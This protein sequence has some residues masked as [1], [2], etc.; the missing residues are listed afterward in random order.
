MQEL[1]YPMKSDDGSLTDDCA[2]SQW[3]KLL[4]EAT[5]KIGQ[6][7]NKPAHY[8][9]W[10][11]QAGFINT[12]TVIYRWPT[13]PWPK[14]PKLKTK[15]LWNLYNSLKGLQAFTVGLFTRVLGWEIEE[16]E[17]LLARVR[18]DLQNPRIHAYWNMFVTTF[19]F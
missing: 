7:A 9:E 15:G 5:M 6:G 2:L 18:N 8:E 1:Y 4:L 17:V 14:D 19:T 10:M 16:I 13:N 11:R 12:Q 3:S